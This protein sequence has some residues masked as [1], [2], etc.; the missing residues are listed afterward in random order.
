M[1]QV[2]KVDLG[3][4]YTNDEILLDEKLTSKWGNKQVTKLHGQK[5]LVGVRLEAMGSSTINW[6]S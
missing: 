2:Y 3:T 4:H 1:D 6:K 5:S